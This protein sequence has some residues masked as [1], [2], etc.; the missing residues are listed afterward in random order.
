MQNGTQDEGDKSGSGESS[1][2]EHKQLRELK[3]NKKNKDVTVNIRHEDKDA[4]FTCPKPK[5]EH[6]M[7]SFGPIISVEERE[8][9]A[10]IFD[11]QLQEMEKQKYTEREVEE[12]N[13][14]KIFSMGQTANKLKNPQKIP[15]KSTL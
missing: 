9:I 15:K 3:G 5:Y 14:D 6:N 1:D 10:E 13:F 4:I 11:K 12:D 2:E 7:A 8:K